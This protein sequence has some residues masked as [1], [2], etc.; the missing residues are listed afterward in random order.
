MIPDTI[1]NE[2]KETRGI[3]AYNKKAD[4]LNALESIKIKYMID[5]IDV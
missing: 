1:N 5:K 3:R 4:E 2:L